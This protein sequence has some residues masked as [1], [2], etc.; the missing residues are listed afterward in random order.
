MG[1][2]LLTLVIGQYAHKWHLP[3]THKNLTLTVRAWREFESQIIPLPH[4]S[5]RNNIWLSKN[6]WFADEL[7]PVLK[8]RVRGAM[9]VAV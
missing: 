9:R 2:K 1:L 8:T 3:R 6:P 4:P 5:P 7:L